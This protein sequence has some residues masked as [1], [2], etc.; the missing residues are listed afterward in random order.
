MKK[1]LALVLCAVLLVM[2][3]VPAMAKESSAAVTQYG[4]AAKADAAPKIDGVID[5]VWAKATAYTIGNFT[6]GDQDTGIKATF[7]VLWDAENLYVL[8]EVPDT[9][10]FYEHNDAHQKDGVELKFDLNNLKT[11]GAYEDEQQFRLTVFRE[12]GSI[13]FVVSESVWDEGYVTAASVENQTNYIVEI[14]LNAS[15]A[16]FKLEDNVMIGMD[17]QINDNALDE[18][19]TACFAW[20]DDADQAWQNASYMGNMTL[21]AGAAAPAAETKDEPAVETKDAPVVEETP[22]AAPEATPEPTPAPVQSAPPTGDMTIIFCLTAI[23]GAAVV[24][25]RIIKAKY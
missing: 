21:M 3:A 7:K 14:A 11:D 23:L 22:E 15:K 2:L 18:G 25:F 6:T 16:G 4:E 9:T 17:A 5:D 20:N 12:D 19:R 1:K 13:N 10:P 8:F 24:S